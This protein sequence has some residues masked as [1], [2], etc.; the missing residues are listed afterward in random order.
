MRFIAIAIAVTL[1]AGCSEP[2]DKARISIQT[3]GVTESQNV[4]VKKAAEVLFDRCPG[5]AQYAQDIEWVKARTNIVTPDGY[6]GYQTRDYGWTTW[7]AFEVKVADDARRIPNE[8]RAW[9]H[10]LFYDV[11]SSPRPGVN[12][13][14][15]TAGWFCGIGHQH[16]FIPA[17]EATVVDELRA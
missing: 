15:A 11:G 17:Q 2:S 7:V 6:G 12:V 1:I 10:H 3:E 13:A 5:L 14:K 16:G 8:W 4:V 9:G